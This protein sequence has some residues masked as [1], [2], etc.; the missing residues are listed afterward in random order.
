MGKHFADINVVAR[1]DNGGGSV[2]VR[3][4][5]CYG[6]QIH[7]CVLLMEFLIHG[8]TVTKFSVPK[9]HSN[10]SSV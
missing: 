4:D 6:L 7:R 1:V 5:V 10:F 9:L 3:A 2:M 8:D